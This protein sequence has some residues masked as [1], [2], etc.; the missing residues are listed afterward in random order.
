M[1]SGRYPVPRESAACARQAR[2]PGGSSAD[3]EILPDTWLRGVLPQK[4]EGSEKLFLL[5]IAI[6]TR[7]PTLGQRV[8]GWSRGRRPYRGPSRTHSEGRWEEEQSR[9][10]GEAGVGAGGSPP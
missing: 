3:N 6:E 10:P 8:P 5:L 4:A 7:H 9:K 1:C 2:D